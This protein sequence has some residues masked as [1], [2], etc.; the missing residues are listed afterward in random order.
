MDDF[1]FI[2]F[3]P[4]LA[5]TVAGGVGSS[6]TGFRGIGPAWARGLGASAMMGKAGKGESTPFDR[7]LVV[8]GRVVMSILFFFGGSGAGGTS[9]SFRGAVWNLSSNPGGGVGRALEKRERPALGAR[10]EDIPMLSAT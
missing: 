4:E 8:E 1:L 3:K 6:A 5:P 2:A 9:G 10:S 7:R